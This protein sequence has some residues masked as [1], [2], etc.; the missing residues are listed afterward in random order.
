MKSLKRVST[1]VAVIV[2]FLLPRSAFAADKSTPAAFQ[3]WAVLAAPEL[4]DSGLSDL[5]TA[6]LSSAEIDLVEREQL[7]AITK[8][9]ELSK[10]LGADEAT[11]R[12]K[13]GQL[14]KADALV[15]LSLVE[16]DKKKF[17]KLV[18]S[19][20]RYGSRLRLDH[21]PFAT[22][23]IERL[24][25]DMVGS[26]EETRQQFAHGVER[27]VA[28]SPFLSKNLTHEFD[29]LQ[30]G[31]AAL[32]GQSLSERPG[33]AVLEIE[34]AR[35]IGEELRR[36]ASDLQ[37]RTV[38]LFIVGDYEVL[39]PKDRGQPASEADGRVR[40]VL[41]VLD[42]RAERE[43]VTQ[44]CD[45]LA[46]TTT[47]LT[48]T[49]PPKLLGRTEDGAMS[50]PLTHRQQHDLL[51]QRA[52][53]F[54]RIAS[55][56]QSTSLREAALLLDP[57][58]WEQRV[59]L[60]VDH[61]R[62]LRL[63]NREPSFAK[64]FD[65]RADPK[66]KAEWRAELRTRLSIMMQHLEVVL[67]ADVLNPKE[68]ELLLSNAAMPMHFLVGNE[69]LL[70][71]AR[72]EFLEFFWR[73][74]RHISRLEPTIRNGRVHPA[75]FEMSGSFTATQQRA[76]WVGRAV[77]FITSILPRTLTSFDRRALEWTER[78]LVEFLPEDHLVYSVLHDMA[79]NRNG[80]PELVTSHHVK[81]QDL[82]AMYE[83]LRATQRP[84]LEFY[85]RF[86]L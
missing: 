36:S 20:C 15:L 6:K 42:G 48:E 18:I 52:E 9:I 47:W 86:G 40:L 54:S 58:D 53:M 33:T 83:R 56:S 57:A 76:Q 23:G 63:Q 66:L 64:F 19:D 46:D 43:S 5:L 45:S 30:F 7:D 39:P 75:V 34:E 41:R 70:M 12:L 14:L 28:V 55:F 16:N 49:L 79:R 2:A 50:K 72:E 74:L 62:W 31:F 10:L 1:L 21:F 82:V 24:V 84:L 73:C 65:P 67:A 85:A 13:V 22:D 37:K 8:E 69:H 32:L 81:S 51:T 78:L 80:I 11:Q 59:R 3:R 4:R 35:A 68:G 27:I 44:T 38:P 17:V 71:E 77:S 29:H 60:V 25:Q 61:Q 26:V